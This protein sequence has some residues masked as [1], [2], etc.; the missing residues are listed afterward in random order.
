MLNDIEKLKQQQKRIFPPISIDLA[1]Y[2]APLTAILEGGVT[3]TTETRLKLS[4][5]LAEQ[6]GT[7]L[8][9]GWLIEVSGLILENCGISF[10][11]HSH[12]PIE[13]IETIE[14]GLF[15]ESSSEEFNLQEQMNEAGLGEF[16]HQFVYMICFFGF[17]K[18]DL[19]RPSQKE[20]QQRAQ[21]YDSDFVKEI[22]KSALVFA[23][24]VR[25]EHPEWT[26]PLSGDAMKRIAEFALSN[27]F[28]SSVIGVDTSNDKTKRLVVDQVISGPVEN[29]LKSPFFAGAIQLS[30]R[31][32]E[33]TFTRIMEAFL[34]T[35]NL[36]NAHLHTDV[37]L[38]VFLPDEGKKNEG[39]DLQL[40]GVDSFQ[41][42]QVMIRNFAEAIHAQPSSLL[43]AIEKVAQ[44]I[45]RREVP[46]VLHTRAELLNLIYWNEIPA[47]VSQQILE[48]GANGRDFGN[49]QYYLE[50]RGQQG[51]SAEV[52]LQWMLLEPPSR[53][54]VVR[55]LYNF[56]GLNGDHYGFAS[57]A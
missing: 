20:D 22:P 25:L 40:Q 3:A 15:S 33:A 17:A 11:R 31:E 27:R 39:N 5:E 16:Y 52:A 41:Q 10:A 6:W 26:T 45:N 12:R 57:A 1:S 29:G 24:Q 38:H 51:H 50:G 8:G 36:E 30:P 49:I 56:F 18:L 28:F 7:S 43:E 2:E 54:L 23:D 14:I 42:L 47:A 46:V 19:S 55:S 44:A 35:A 13:V 21:R 48:T 9:R 4:E 37:R 34:P 53:E 32:L